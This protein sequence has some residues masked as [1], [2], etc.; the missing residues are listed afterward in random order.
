MVFLIKKEIYRTE[1]EGTIVFEGV[2]DAEESNAKNI[3]TADRKHNINITCQLPQE[4]KWAAEREERKEDRVDRE[5]VWEE[6][7]VAERAQCKEDRVDRAQVCKEK[8]A[9]WLDK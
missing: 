4:E 2:E 9:Q 8:R 6:E 1:Y 7:R 5:Q 3:T